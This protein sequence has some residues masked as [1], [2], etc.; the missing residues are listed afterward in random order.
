MFINN[1]K[2]FSNFKFLSSQ[3]DTLIHQQKIHLETGGRFFFLNFKCKCSSWLGF[4]SSFILILIPVFLSDL[5][6]SFASITFYRS[7]MPYF[8]GGSDSKKKK[9]RLPT[10]REIRVQSLDWEDLLEK[11]MA[12]HSSVLAWKIPWTEEPD[13]L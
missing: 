7:P 3:C 11:E 5:L 12:T 1:T 4:Q 10:M 2:V 13:G 8:P 9:K 6:C